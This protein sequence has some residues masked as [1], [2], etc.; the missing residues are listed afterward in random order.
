MVAGIPRIESA[1]CVKYTKEIQWIPCFS[2]D[3]KD[4]WDYIPEA[5]GRIFGFRVK[6]M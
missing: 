4:K 1:P 6:I 5:V 3:V 2:S